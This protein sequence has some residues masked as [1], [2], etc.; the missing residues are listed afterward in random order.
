MKGKSGQ[1]IST[2]SRKAEGGGR[3]LLGNAGR[4]RLFEVVIVDGNLISQSDK[5]ENFSPSVAIR[6]G[7]AVSRRR[8]RLSHRA[9]TLLGRITEPEMELGDCGVCGVC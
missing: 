7:G 6:T 4:L 9:D 8:C 3:D 5:S 1:P 2:C